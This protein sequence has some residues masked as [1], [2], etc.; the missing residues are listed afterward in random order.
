[1]DKVKDILAVLKKHHFWVLIGVLAL[2]TLISW[3]LATADL[4]VQYE[5]R[6]KKIDG[7]FSALSAVAAENEHPNEGTIA[8]I[9][10]L[11]GS[12]QDDRSLKGKVFTA[13]QSL[14]S[15]QKEKNQLPSLL[16]EGFKIEFERITGTK[17][18][19]P[20]EFRELYHS[21]IN[22]HL[23]TLREIVQWRHP[24][25][26]PAAGAAAGEGAAGVPP[27]F[28]GLPGGALPTVGPDVEM[29][30]VVDW[31][32]ESWGKIQ[33][34]F[35]WRARPTT[36]EVVLAQEDLWVYEALLRVIANTNAGVTEHHNAAVKQIRQLNIGQDAAQPWSALRQKSADGIAGAEG[37]PG[38]GA[39]EAVPVDPT[40]APAGD[41]TLSAREV[42]LLNGRYVDDKDEPLVG[43]ANPPY[44][45]FKM[46]PI[47]M[48]LL[49]DQ[50]KISKLLAECANSSMPIEV[51]SFRLRPG[52]GKPL[53]VTALAEGQAASDRA[54]P[55]DS[56]F[57]GFGGGQGGNAYG[58]GGAARTGLSADSAT[59][60]D[61]PVEIQG[62]IYIFNPPD[63]NKLGTGTAGAEAPPAEAVPGEEPAAPETP[64]A[65]ATPVAPPAARPAAAPAAPPAAPPATEP[66]V[67]PPVA[68]PT[69][70]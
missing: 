58:E 65:P 30:G 23:P 51:K 52:Q 63:M 66:A 31:S 61:V 37:L 56:A 33:Q 53:N 64:T 36:P 5:T 4:A 40:A 17:R 6:K 13:W 12:S 15:Q 70:N 47:H 3:Q 41:G 54:Y 27:A 46:M 43:G 20:P 45:E 44:A 9:Q 8:L 16:G 29:V 22:R 24:K 69:N 7:H 57:G 25:V 42:Q 59:Y 19:L 50:R 32:L 2:I 18:D 34:H 67:V 38:S 11:I 55:P 48:E 26:D 35:D 10:E 1:M 49:V 60:W 68:A 14:Y 21:F 62:I 28:G 39:I